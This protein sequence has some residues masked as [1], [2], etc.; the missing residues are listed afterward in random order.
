[1]PDK[2]VDASILN[3][4]PQAFAP[5]EN[6]APY[7]YQEV[8][9]STTQKTAAGWPHFRRI[10]KSFFMQKDRKLSNDTLKEVVDQIRDSDENSQKYDP[11]EFF[12]NPLSIRTK[13]PSECHLLGLG[14]EYCSCSSIRVEKSICLRCETE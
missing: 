7:S 14:S 6:N 3:V 2:E 10:S 9:L 8:P 4:L 13:A 5:F 12:T 11:H 1:M